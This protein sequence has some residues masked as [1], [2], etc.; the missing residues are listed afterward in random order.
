MDQSIIQVQLSLKEDHFPKFFNFP[1]D[2]VLETK[3]TSNSLL[4]TLKVPFLNFTNYHH[5]TINWN[6]YDRLILLINLSSVLT[7]AITNEKLDELVI[8]PSCFFFTSN[9]EAKVLNIGNRSWVKFAKIFYNNEIFE[10]NTSTEGI[11]IKINNLK[12]VFLKSIITLLSSFTFV[13]K[14]CIF[15]VMNEVSGH[16]ARPLQTFILENWFKNVANEE[17]L[18][19][20]IEEAAELMKTQLN[21]NKQILMT[22]EVLDNLHVRYIM[23][24]ECFAIQDKTFNYSYNY[25]RK[26]KTQLRPKV[27]EILKIKV[28]AGDEGVAKVAFFACLFSFS[29]VKNDYGSSV[30]KAKEKKRNVLKPDELERMIANRWTSGSKDPRDEMRLVFKAPQQEQERIVFEAKL[31][32]LR[33]SLKGKRI[34]E[35]KLLNNFYQQNFNV[36]TTKQQ[37]LMDDLGFPELG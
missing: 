18:V 34:A 15:D 3:S 17:Q 12:F 6:D 10:I 33:D 37:I 25:I 21:K 13:S 26:F 23:N 24:A 28:N 8:S 36:E 9:K 29:V 5:N 19:D 1:D 7:Q 11:F 16:V 2:I 31:K 27:E 14:A 30:A 20:L 32:K 35:D 22:K 4:F